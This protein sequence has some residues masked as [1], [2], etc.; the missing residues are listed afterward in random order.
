MNIKT[1]NI[2]LNVFLLSLCSCANL[3]TKKLLYKKSSWFGLLGGSNNKYINYL[4]V[5]RNAL[6]F[7]YAL[8]LV[9]KVGCHT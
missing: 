5:I 7:H 8:V 1:K 4:S 2:F 9:V 3:G 6:Y